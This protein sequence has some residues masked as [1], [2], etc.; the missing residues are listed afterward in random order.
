MNQNH[1][2][3]PS[4]IGAAGGRLIQDMTFLRN[5]PSR[6]SEVLHRTTHAEISET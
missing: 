1:S 6:P 4:R 5:L 2:F 3:I